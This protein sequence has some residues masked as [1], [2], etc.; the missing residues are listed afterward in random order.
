MWTMPLLSVQCPIASVP[1]VTQDAQQSVRAA[2]SLL[3]SRYPE[4]H[5]LMVM[6]FHR[7]YQAAID[8]SPNLSPDCMPTVNYCL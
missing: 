2:S 6:C 7:Y 4:D 8:P 1:R 5:P 3:K